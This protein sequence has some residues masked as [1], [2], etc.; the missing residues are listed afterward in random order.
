MIEVK[1]TIASPLRFIVSRNEWEQADKFGPAYL[2]HVWDMQKNP[3]VL[4]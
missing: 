4:E 2:F 3:P 1:S